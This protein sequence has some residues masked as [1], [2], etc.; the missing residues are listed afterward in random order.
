[1]YELLTMKKT[2]PLTRLVAMEEMPPRKG[3]ESARP[4]AWRRIDV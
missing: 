2:I 1:M 3:M 4:M